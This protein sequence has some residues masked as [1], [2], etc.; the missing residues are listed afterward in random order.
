MT[1]N[2]PTATSTAN[3]IS[4]T[5]PSP[6]LSRSHPL[7][8][9]Y[10]LSLLHSR[11]SHAHAPH[12]LPSTSTSGFTLHLGALGKGKSCPAELRCPRHLIVPFS[13]T[14]YD[15]EDPNSSTGTASRKGAAQTP[16]VGTVDLEKHYFDSYSKSSPVP[17]DHPPP[18][19]PGYLVAPVGQLQVLVRTPTQAL[20]VF[21]VPYDLRNLPVGGRLLARERTYV[22]STSGNGRESLRYAFQLQFTCAAHTDVQ[23]KKVRDSSTTRRRKG[24][25]ESGS[26]STASSRCPTPT[27]PGLPLPG[28]DTYRGKAFYVSKSLKVVFTSSPPEKDELQRTERTDELVLPSEELEG[29]RGRVI[30]FSPGSLGR[31]MDDWE[32]VRRK[33]MARKEVEEAQLAPLLFLSNSIN[34]PSPLT[35]PTK[36]ISPLPILSPLPRLPTILARSPARPSTPIRTAP[37][38]LPSVKTP[39]AQRYHRQGSRRG[40]GSMEEREL[41]EKLRAMGMKVGAE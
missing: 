14:Y 13:A 2:S 12:S 9:S 31:R 40:S 15:L 11:M 26:A 19:H 36:P 32:M 25:S 39:N 1:P 8:G 10:P 17:N 23:E 21:L 30:G 20:K 41:S 7:L 34:S 18:P 37:P 38:Q 27:L 33:W 29:T 5:S 28:V 35:S 22:Q 6:P 24:A 16:W 4:N 3:P